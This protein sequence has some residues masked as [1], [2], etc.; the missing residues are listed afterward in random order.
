MGRAATL[1]D[2]GGV[3]PTLIV[4]QG[5]NIDILGHVAVREL[6]Y[7]LQAAPTRTWPRILAE[8]QVASYHVTA[9]GKAL[10]L[11]VTKKDLAHLRRIAEA[12][13]K[14]RDLESAS[15]MTELVA[16]SGEAMRK[17]VAHE[18]AARCAAG[19]PELARRVGGGLLPESTL[20]SIDADDWQALIVE[21]W[22][23]LP[24]IRHVTVSDFL[25][26]RVQAKRATNER[27]APGQSAPVELPRVL[28]A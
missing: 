14:D 1:Q 5:E 4:P 13:L 3:A 18:L 28:A 10:G 2:Q 23:I 24:V 21:K 6:F 16:Q 11:R 22:R 15:T 20:A 12:A 25:L 19:G 7:E 17:A 8:R 27:E 26:S 9:G